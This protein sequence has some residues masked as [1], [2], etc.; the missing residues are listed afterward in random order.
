MKQTN[1]T[2]IE[3]LDTRMEAMK[4]QNE[5]DHKEIMDKIEKLCVKLDTR[6]VTRT[7]HEHL[8]QRVKAL[9]NGAMGAISV[10][11][12]AVLGALIKLV[13]I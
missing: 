7:E 1:E 3:V 13:I 10:I 12:L 4:V 2:R 11:L 8:E 5:R 9:A 6:Y